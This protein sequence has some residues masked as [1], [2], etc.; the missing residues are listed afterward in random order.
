MIEFSEIIHALLKF[1]GSENRNHDA[2]ISRSR[3]EIMTALSIT[4]SESWT[5]TRDT[6][7]RPGQ[8]FQ[9]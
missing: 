6:I 7:L 2:A 9:R 1:F 4:E 8:S 5:E 3:Y